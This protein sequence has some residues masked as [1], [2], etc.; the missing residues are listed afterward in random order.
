MAANGTRTCSCDSKPFD[1][2]RVGFHDVKTGKIDKLF[3]FTD[4]GGYFKVQFHSK[5]PYVSKAA[6]CKLFTSSSFNTR[7][8]SVQN[9]SPSMSTSKE[10]QRPVLPRFLRRLRVSRQSFRNPKLLESLVESCFQR[11]FGYSV[12]QNEVRPST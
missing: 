10:P 7:K 6:K 2:I 12:Y 4:H 9:P 8:P 5:F 11:D 1:F 3:I